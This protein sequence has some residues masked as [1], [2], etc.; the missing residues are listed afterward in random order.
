M[1]TLGRAKFIIPPS[2]TKFLADSL[3]LF[4]ITCGSKFGWR[5]F[6]SFRFLSTIFL[7]TCGRT[8]TIFISTRQH[9]RKNIVA[10][11]RLF[12]V[13]RWNHRFAFLVGTWGLRGHTAITITSTIHWRVS[14]FGFILIG[15]V[16][17]L[18]FTTMGGTTM[19]FMTA[20]IGTVPMGF[21][22][23]VRTTFRFIRRG[24]LLFSWRFVWFITR[25]RWWM[26]IL[27]LVRGV[28][29][30]LL[31]WIWNISISLSETETRAAD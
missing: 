12:L 24:F 23:T 31:G 25:F 7:T 29:F 1:K 6:C 2:T 14:W 15:W 19:T 21:A 18:T 4:S 10:G 28:V 17:W 9:W 13:F 20:A 8:I 30:V 26:F 11:Q 5:G 3:A 22:P 27:L 16:F